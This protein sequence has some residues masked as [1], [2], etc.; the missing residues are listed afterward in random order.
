[1]PHPTIFLEV[2]VLK[3]NQVEDKTEDAFFIVQ[4]SNFRGRYQYGAV[5][6]YRCGNQLIS[7]KAQLHRGFI[8]DVFHF[9]NSIQLC[10]AGVSAHY[11]KRTFLK[12]P[13][14][15]IGEIIQILD[16]GA[17][18]LSEHLSRDFSFKCK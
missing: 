1:M 10:R 2:S 17:P 15:P 3:G 4:V 12:F 8:I 6:T 5:A 13:H 16:S 11:L 7:Q 14:S 9:I 18:E